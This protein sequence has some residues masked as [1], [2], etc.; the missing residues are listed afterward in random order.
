MLF[1]STSDKLIALMRKDREDGEERARIQRFARRYRL[2]TDD[3][4]DLVI[5]ELRRVFKDPAQAQHVALLGDVSLNVFKQVVEEIY[6]FTG[7]KRAFVTG[8]DADPVYDRITREIVDFDLVMGEV[9]QAIGGM[10]DCL[11]RILPARVE[12]GAAVGTPSIRVFLPH[13]VTV[14]ES[15]DDPSVAEAVM[16]EQ[17]LAGR[18][19]ELIVWTA[20]EHY[21]LD[22]HGNKLVPAGATSIVNELGRLPFV[23][24]HRGLRPD[25][26]WD[27]SS[28]EDLVQ[29]TLQHNAGWSSVR[30]LMHQQ[31]FRQLVITGA[32]DDAPEVG[33]IGPGTTIQVESGVEVEV[34]D[35]NTDPR[36]QTETLYAMLAQKLASYGFNVEDFRQNPGQAPPSGLARYLS[37]QRI[38]ERRR[39]IRPFLTEAEYG[40]AELYRWAWNWNQPEKISESAVFRVELIEETVVMSPM[41]Q[42]EVR[43]A[44]LDVIQRERELGLRTAVE[45]ISADRG[46]TPEA[47]EEIAKTL[48]A[49]PEIF[50]YH[51]ENGM[52]TRNQVLESLGFGKTDN[53][54]DDLTL[55]ELRAKYPE[56]YQTS[57]AASSA[58]GE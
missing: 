13:E 3:Y 21:A 38:L 37:R 18:D 49:K 55:P 17:Q 5:D 43:K 50:G 8:E 15:H 29:F 27:S 40:I 16:Y 28:G 19:S 48:R 22:K 58:A 46:V 11:V 56:R 6:R 10:N 33:A 4:L 1:D 12:N 30:F 57:G 2:Q 47:A 51:I 23:A 39:R 31:S 26:F 20:T 14:V 54:D 32:S 42:V 41:E 45:Q 9:S 36:G 7:A 25:C 34:L 24:V 35:L 52:V 53:P 44:Q